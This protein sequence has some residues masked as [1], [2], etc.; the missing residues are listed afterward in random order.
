MDAFFLLLAIHRVLVLA[1]VYEQET[2]SGRVAAALKE[3]E[4]EAPD[5]KDLRDVMM[6][7]DDYSRGKGKRPE[8]EADGLWWPG[9]GIDLKRDEL[10]FRAGTLHVELKRAARAGLAL[11]A[12]LNEIASD[13]EP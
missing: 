4:R 2:D 9:V 7:L 8:F 13:H 6:H 12:T 11:S 3:F 1:S 10:D 5:V